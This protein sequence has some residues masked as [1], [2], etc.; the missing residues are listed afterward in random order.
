MNNSNIS[1]TLTEST[2]GGSH[3]PSVVI[4]TTI[5]ITLS[6]L[7][8]LLAFAYTILILVRP[9]FRRNKLNWFTVNIT[10]QTT[11]F[12]TLMF[13]LSIEQSSNDSK[14][15]PCRIQG[16]LLNMAVCQMLY[17]HCVAS[18]CRLLALVYANKHLFRSSAFT[19]ICMATGW[20]AS[21]SVG[22]PYL[23]LDGFGCQGE[24]QVEFLSYYT[25]ATSLALPMAI[26]GVCNTRIL[27][28]VRRSTRQ[29]HAEAV[30]KTGPHGR[31][32]Q[33]MKTLIGTFMILV[34]GWAPSFM[35]E[36]FLNKVTLPSVVII[37]I[38]VLPSVSTLLDVSLLI[39]TNQPVRIY[40]K[41]RIL[42]RAAPAN[43]PNINRN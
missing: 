10:L 22:V 2:F 37:G 40:L 28:F 15:L 4:P 20:L 8:I 11:L 25:I 5:E 12:S 31:D 18:F 36:T 6:S 38:Q 19:W 35:V 24:N 42:R 7:T 27:R 23:L 41:Q 30:K 33:L 3:R 16:Y 13:S 43:P 39:Y 32:L 1:L 21:F 17:S 29:V 34:I 26:V 9:T 14:G